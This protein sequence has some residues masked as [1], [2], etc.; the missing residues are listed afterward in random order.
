MDVSAGGLAALAAA[1][2]SVMGVV[3]FAGGRGSRG[4][5]MVCGG[6]ELIRAA[7]LYGRASRVPELWIYS[8]N[9][10]FFGPVVARHLF[11]AFNAAGGQAT[12]VA[13][14]PYADDGHKY[15]ADIKA[16]KP[17]VDTFLRQI[18][19]LPPMK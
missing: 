8:E 19:F 11:D 18:G 16:W 5:E 13:A 3:N 12:F 10:H 14:P 7:G 9:N 15:I 6:T 17:R 1:K 2:G 4:P